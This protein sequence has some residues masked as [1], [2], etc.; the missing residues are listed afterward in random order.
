MA[1]LR[2][3]TERFWA[4]LA[5]IVA[6]GVALRLVQTLAVAPS[7][8][9]FTDGFYFHWVA[10][11]VADGHGFV[12]PAEMLFRAHAVPTASHPPLYTLVLAG[13]TKLGITGDAAQRSLGCVF[14]AGTIVLTGLLGRRAAG[15]AV[16]L[17][18]A[19]IAA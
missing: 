9:L 16:G 13:A 5:A 11:Y 15:R 3:D 12:N 8:G 7:T 14:G 2:G 6:A 17:G 19:A 10:R 18:A 4:P 1:G